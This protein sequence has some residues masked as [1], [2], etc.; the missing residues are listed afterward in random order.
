M[1]VGITVGLLMVVGSIGWA[2]Y[3]IVKRRLRQQSKKSIII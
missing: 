2:K 3:T 1:A